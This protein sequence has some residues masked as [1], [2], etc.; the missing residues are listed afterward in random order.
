LSY[1]VRVR[2][3]LPMA[4]LQTTDSGDLKTSPYIDRAPRRKNSQVQ[5]NVKK[6]FIFKH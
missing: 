1:Y 5:Q 3:R 4:L 6:E 2:S